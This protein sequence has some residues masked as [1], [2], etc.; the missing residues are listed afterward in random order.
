[1]AVAGLVAGAAER[2]AMQQRAIVADHRRLADDDAS[3]MVEHDALADARR[4]MNVDLQNARRKALKIE[5]EVM[6]A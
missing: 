2:D 3:G 5:R 1:M 4:R 6:P